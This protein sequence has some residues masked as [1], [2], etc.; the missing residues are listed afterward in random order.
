M[1]KEGYMI[2]FSS[3]ENDADARKTVT[4]DGLSLAQAKAYVYLASNF[5]SKNS[6]EKP[7]FGNSYIKDGDLEDLLIDVE[8]KHPVM[9]GLIEGIDEFY[10]FLCG[11]IL[12]WPVDEIYYEKEHFCRVCDGYVVHYIEDFIPEVTL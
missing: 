1:I 12:G 4:I 8:E 10:E 9:K 6:R 3:W 5:E 7:G 11:N 2:E